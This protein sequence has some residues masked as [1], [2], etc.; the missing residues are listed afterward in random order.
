MPRQGYPDMLSCM[1]V[2]MLIYILSCGNFNAPYLNTYRFILVAR[3]RLD[4]L[5]SND[6]VL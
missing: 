5:L 2:Y 6:V 4:S 3:G 1:L